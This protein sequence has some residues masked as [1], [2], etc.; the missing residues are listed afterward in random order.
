M[1]FVISFS[2]KKKLIDEKWKITSKNVFHGYLP[3]RYFESYLN[4][5]NNF[6]IFLQVS[7]NKNKTRAPLGGAL[8]ARKCF[9]LVRMKHL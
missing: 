3:F 7:F 8:Y 6:S 2:L 4:L 5:M 1:A 9:F